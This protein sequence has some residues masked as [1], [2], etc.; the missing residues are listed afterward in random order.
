[1]GTLSNLKIRSIFSYRVKRG[2]MNKKWLSP[3]IGCPCGSGKLFAQCCLPFLQGA[4]EASTAEQLMRSRYSANVVGKFQYILKTWCPAH[5]PDTLDPEALVAWCGL[6]IVNVEGGG[7]GEPR[8]WVEFRADYLEQGRLQVLHEK[9][10]FRT[11]DGK[12]RYVDGVI[13]HGAN[14]GEK[15]GRNSPCPCGSGK[16]YKRCCMA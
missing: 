7:K 9:S 12:W 1:M 10:S 16:K 2:S 3:V 14:Q 8:G 5:R 15:T 6:Q 11:V 4:Q 13:I